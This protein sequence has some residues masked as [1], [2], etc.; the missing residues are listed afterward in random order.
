MYQQS[1]YQQ[2]TQQQQNGVPW[3]PASD[4]QQTM[5]AGQ[6]M[7]SGDQYRYA[8]QNFRIA[9]EKVEEQRL[10]LEEQE[11]QVAQLRARIN[12]LEGGSGLQ[13]Q[14]PGGNTIDDFSI[15][16]AASQ[17]DKLINRWA[18]DTIRNPPVP[19]RDICAAILS[20]VSSA[21]G[22]EIDD[23]EGTPMQIQAYLRH[24]MAEVIS[25]GIINCLIVTNS[26]EANI[27]LTRIHEHIFARDP[28]VAR[29][30]RRQTFSAAVEFCAPDLTASIVYEHIPELMRVLNGALPVSGGVSVLDSAYTFSRMLHSSGSNSGDAFYRAFVPE[31]GST[32]YPRQIELVKR[33]LR[34]E[35]G[36][37]DRVGATIFPGLVKVSEGLKQ[38]N[39]LIGDKLQTVVRR[40]QVICECALGG[41]VGSSSQTMLGKDAPGMPPPP[42]T[43]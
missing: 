41:N 11:R 4:S 14:G 17:L 7:V 3:H 38:P 31:L 18:A 19:L 6:D 12:L 24:A 1:V 20:D 40:A 23:V 43:M 27:Q 25:E 22:L 10:Q 30:W 28:T 5:V 16:N 39:G 13:I 9:H 36:E 29:I 37:L 33:C 8:L 32:L 42:L 21:T 34:S 26:T 2:P 15:K 35:R